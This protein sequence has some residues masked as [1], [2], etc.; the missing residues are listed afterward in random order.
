MSTGRK[1][2]AL[3]IDFPEFHIT[4]KHVVTVFRLEFHGV[5]RY[6]CKSRV[7]TGVG[8]ESGAASPWKLKISVIHC[9]QMRVFYTVSDPG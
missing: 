2:G 7:R 8:I 4:T 6:L 1:W 3:M 9:L 5:F